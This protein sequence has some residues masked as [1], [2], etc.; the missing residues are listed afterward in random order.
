MKAVRE[1]PHEVVLPP[2]QADCLH[3]VIPELGLLHIAPA[4]RR[5]Q[6]HVVDIIGVCSVYYDPPSLIVFPPNNECSTVLG[7]VVNYTESPY[8]VLFYSISSSCL[9]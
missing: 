1:A 8:F 5:I 2:G 6:V 7:K 9:A 4:G 3:V